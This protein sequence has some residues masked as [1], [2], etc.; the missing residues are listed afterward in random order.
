MKLLASLLFSL[1]LVTT[2][3]PPKD[4]DFERLGNG[5]ALDH[6]LVG[7]SDWDVDFRTILRDGYAHVPLGLFEVYHPIPDLEDKQTAEA[8]KGLCLVLL[9]M[10]QLWLDML[11]PESGRLKGAEGDLE[12]VRK[13]VSKWSTSKLGKLDKEGEHDLLA[14]LKASDRYV[15][16]ATRLR[17]SFLA[18][19][20]LGMLRE[21]AEPAALVL[22]PSR[23][24]FV[25]LVCYAGLIFEDERDN[26]WDEGLSTWIE[27]RI[28]NV[29]VLALEYLDTASSDGDPLAGAPMNVRREDEREQH[30][31]QRA[32]LSLLQSY[33]GERMD[34]ALAVGLAINVCIDLF[35]K[36]HARM[37]GDPRGNSTPPR[38][39]F[40][41]GGNPNGGLLPP[42][43]A[44]SHWREF[45]GEFRYFT[46]LKQSQ[47]AGNRPDQDRVEEYGSFQIIDDAESNQR[48]IHA[49]FLGS[50]ALDAP[51]PPAQ[52]V[53]DYQEFFRAYRTVFSE[54]LRTGAGGSKKSSAKDFAKLMTLLATDEEER[55]LEELVPEVFDDMPLSS[56]EPGK[57]DLEGRFLRWLEKQKQK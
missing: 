51:M 24:E 29:R 9:D 49:P 41:P 30:V 3:P 20:S 17:D 13:W 22:C 42:L 8:F 14:A 21:E 15:D 54:Y 52:F 47:G 18:G 6:D 27:G 50:P 46:K 1:I 56:D 44:D 19:E 11:E 12:T 53:G 25:R 34:P 32:F 33:Y 55:D 48:V 7:M 43:N 38:E 4:I 10:Q 39:V 16:A 2:P 28:M 57:G 31:A 45:E 5:F 35:G 36:D 23:R 26:Y 40:V 37:E